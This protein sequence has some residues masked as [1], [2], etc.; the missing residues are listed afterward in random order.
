MAKVP[1]I[2]GIKDALRPELDVALEVYNQ[3]LSHPWT[4]WRICKVES[5]IKEDEAP[6][7]FQWEW[8][9]YVDSQATKARLDYLIHNLKKRPGFV[10]PRAK[11]GWKIDGRIINNSLYDKIK[12][13]V[14]RKALRTYLMEKYNWTMAGFTQ[15]DWAARSKALCT[16]PPGQKVTILKIYTWV[17][18]HKKAPAT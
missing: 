3:R 10:F 9:N 17:V 6:D 12:H 11:E 13:C 16:T 15:I 1:H 5:H 4:P 18:G 14:N 2:L 8:N 7:F